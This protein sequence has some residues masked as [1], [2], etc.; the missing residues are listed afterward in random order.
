[1]PLPIDLSTP[2]IEGRL[3]VSKSR[4]LPILV[5]AEE[6][7]HLFDS[8]GPFFIFDGSRPV[9][10]EEMLISKEAFLDAY[11]SY[12]EGI[13]QGAL[14]DETPFRFLFSSFF[15]SSKEL[16][17]AQS[18][19]NG[20]YLLKP[21]R[22]VIQLKRHHFIFSNGEFHSGVMGSESVTWGLEFSYPTLFLDPKTR[23]ISKVDKNPQFPNTELFAKL[24]KWVRNNTLPT[25]FLIDD[26]QVNQP[27]RLGKG[28]LDW[29]NQHPSLKLR[30]LYVGRRKNPSNSH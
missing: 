8:L 19:P 9:A 15:S 14:V 27:I 16:V 24:A 21:R 18:L 13:R 6:M 4:K 30:N 12:V 10:E 5:D 17:Y 20:K 7:A 29:I 25:P 22:P 1:M 28:C 23:S 3:E 11:G 26:K 2:E